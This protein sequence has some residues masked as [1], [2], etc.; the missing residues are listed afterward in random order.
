MMAHDRSALS[1]TLNAPAAWRPA[2]GATVRI[3]LP[4]EATCPECPHFHGEA[5]R[6]GRI[7]KD[8]APRNAPSHQYLVI[9][10]KQ[11]NDDVHLDWRM[12]I[13]ARHYAADELE[14]LSVA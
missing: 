6:T 7:V 9:L 5:G 12:T 11:V 2:V 8:R 3:V 14:P 10:D 4:H 1:A 13:L